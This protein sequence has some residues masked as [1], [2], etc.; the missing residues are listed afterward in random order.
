MA[1]PSPSTLSDPLPSLPLELQLSIFSYLPPHS[2]FPLR[3]TS[4]SWNIMLSNPHLLQALHAHLP[5][6]TSAPSLL[7]RLKRRQRMVRNEPVWVKRHSEAFPWCESISARLDDSSPYKYIA[8]WNLHWKGYLAALTPPLQRTARAVAGN[9]D[10]LGVPVASPY[11][12][13]LGIGHVSTP[14]EVAMVDISELLMEKYPTFWHEGRRENE[15]SGVRTHVPPYM[16][17]RYRNTLNPFH[18]AFH[19]GRVLVGIWLEGLGTASSQEKMWNIIFFVFDVSGNLVSHIYHPQPLHLTADYL[20]R[21][22]LNTTY[23]A[24]LIVSEISSQEEKSSSGRV[25]CTSFLRL[26]IYSLHTCQPISKEIRIKPVDDQQPKPTRNQDRYLNLNK[27]LSMFLVDS[28]G[29]AWFP[30]A[31]WGGE[32]EFHTQITDIVS[33]EEET[34]VWGMS[35]LPRSVCGEWVAFPLVEGTFPLVEE[36][37]RRRISGVPPKRKEGK[38]YFDCCIEPMGGEVILPGAVIKLTSPTALA[39]SSQS[40]ATIRLLLPSHFGPNYEGN[41][42]ALLPHP[43]RIIHGKWK[44]FNAATYS[45]YVFLIPDNL[46]LRQLLWRVYWKQEAGAAAGQSEMDPKMVWGYVANNYPVE[47]GSRS[48]SR[49]GSGVGGRGWGNVYLLPYEGEGGEWVVTGSGLEEVGETL[50]WASNNTD[51]ETVGPGPTTVL[52]AWGDDGLMGWW[53][54]R[55]IFERRRRRNEIDI[56]VVCWEEEWAVKGVEVGEEEEEEERVVGGEGEREI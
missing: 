25:P 6:L 38:E 47:G 15:L 18:F 48:G 8:E 14:G 24:T 23:L 56:W 5:F 13:V 34:W 54:A 36:G 3:R 19:E 1:F 10:I 37:M 29:T 33:G 32:V 35:D 2:L 50:G 21:T 41:P 11:K 46:P 26:T 22:S 55:E 4:H 51:R 28:Q 16:P 49:S 7:S 39:S 44:F 30:S 53:A 9:G 17:Q 45:K 43:T 52:L 40:V 31:G 12:C 27:L 42:A 20:L